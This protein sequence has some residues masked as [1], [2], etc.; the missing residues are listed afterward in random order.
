MTSQQARS[1]VIFNPVK[2]DEDELRASVDT[3]V[4]TYGWGEVSWV[5]TSEDEPGENQA[6]QAAEEGVDLVVVCG[7]DGTVRS[8]AAGLHNTDTA[9]GVI[10]QGTGNLLARNLDIP[11]DLDHS[12]EVAY[13]GTT[14]RID[15]CRAD[16]TRPDGSTETIPFA[17]MAGVGID[18]QMIVNTDD[19]LKKK[20]GPLAYA[21]AIFK[22]LGGGN[23]LHVEHQIDDHEVKRSSA[24]TLIVGNCGELVGTIEL[25]PDAEPDDG[26]LDFVLLRP[27]DL[28]GWVQI[29]GRIIGQM[30]T[31]SIRKVIGRSTRVTGGEHE[32]RSLQYATGRSFHAKLS[33]PDVFEIDGDT[34]GEVSEF[35]V[36]LEEKALSVRVPSRE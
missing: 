26:M 2:V 23:R 22:S 17:V 30:I 13:G 10:P 19:D 12:V 33:K 28:L 9:L 34:V 11:L 32:H 5:E 25:I 16:V 7:G 3:Y 21:V 20:I 36:T 15:F 31:K 8:V 24:H 27:Q 1:V 35:R 4:E 6:R 14:R 29:T 18:A